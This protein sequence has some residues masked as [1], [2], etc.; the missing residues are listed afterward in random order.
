M[1][2]IKQKVVKSLTETGVKYELIEIDPTLSDTAAFCSKYGYPLENA[3][4][5]LLAATKSEPKKYC[6]C[7]VLATTR[8]ENKA[9]KDLMKGRTSFASG[10]EMQ[11]LTEMEIGAV[12]P[13]G[14][15][16]EIPVYVDERV[17]RCEWVIVGA[18]K[19]DLKVKVSPEAISRLPHATVISGLAS[20]KESLPSAGEI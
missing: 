12:T 13:F 3:A 5:A 4:N 14:I 17:M 19:R 9:L 6:L 2:D 10:E 8:L 16:Q 7:L 18:G 11:A 15:P 20:L 1:S